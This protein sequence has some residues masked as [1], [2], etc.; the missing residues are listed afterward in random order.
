LGVDLGNA[1]ERNRGPQ[2]D[3][4]RTA[5]RYLKRIHY[6][7]RT[8]LLDNAGHRPRFLDKAQVDTQ[9]G[10]ADWMFE[11]VFDYDDQDAAVPKP[12]D[13]QTKDATGAL[14]YPWKPRPD[15]FSSYR[16]GFEVRTA[17]LCQRVLMFHHFPG[18]AGVERD[19]L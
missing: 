12:N 9:I 4:R 5:N 15:P 18:E 6:G 8:T 16:S 11:V 17:R 10:K 3:A 2:N 19:C 1:H 7:N 14:K 13:D